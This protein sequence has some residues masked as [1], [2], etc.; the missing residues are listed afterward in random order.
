MLRAFV[1]PTEAEAL[2]PE[3]QALSA[4]ELAARCAE[5]GYEEVA[6]GEL[7]RYG[8]QGGHA[9]DAEEAARALMS[10]RGWTH[11]DEVHI[12]SETPQAALD[13]FSPEHFHDDDEVRIISAGEG[14]FD[15]RASDE[16]GAPYLRLIL[17]ARDWISIPPQRYHR[18][19]CTGPMTCSAI[20]LFGENPS[21]TPIYRSEG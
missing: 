3:L 9:E 4:A 6:P 15:V 16:A 20:R 10:E 18:F 1:L 17:G 11:R 2:T 21:W 14:V 19:W 12:T 7:A 13:K 8:F 5:G